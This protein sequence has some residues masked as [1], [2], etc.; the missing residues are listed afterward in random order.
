MMRSGWEKP[1]LENMV[2][3]RCF[4]ES[5]ETTVAPF[6]GNS[7]KSLLDGLREF[8]RDC[9]NVFVGTWRRERNPC[10]GCWDLDVELQLVLV[11]IGGDFHLRYC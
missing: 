4:T 3:I 10:G 2:G 7:W 9:E 8:G 6:G 5:S 1:K 11:F